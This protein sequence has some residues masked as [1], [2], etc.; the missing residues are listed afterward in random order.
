MALTTKG[1]ATP[2]DG[3][4][5][6]R[7]PVADSKGRLSYERTF[8]AKAVPDG[9]LEH[10]SSVHIVQHGIDVNDNGKYDMDALGES[11][12]AKNLGAPGVPEEATD[13]ASC[14]VVMGA[15]AGKPARNGV[16]TG[17]APA[18]DVK[19]PLAVAGGAFLLLSAAFAVSV[20]AQ[21]RGQRVAR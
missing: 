3:L 7:M 6:A 12:F 10:L 15:A 21:R 20:V 2:G 8:S 5:V 18:S 14:G 9:L 4:D 16:E 17:G 19:T 1:G 11:S 13:P